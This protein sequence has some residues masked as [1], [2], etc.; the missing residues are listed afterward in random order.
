MC[1]AAIAYGMYWAIMKSV[2]L[3]YRGFTY[4]FPLTTASLVSFNLLT[5]IYKTCDRAKPIMDP[6]LEFV[7]E[8]LSMV[9]PT[10]QVDLA[11]QIGGVLVCVDLWCSGLFGGAD[12]N[13]H[14]APR[15]REDGAAAPREDGAAAPRAA[16]A[17]VPSAGATPETDDP[18]ATPATPAAPDAPVL[19]RQTWCTAGAAHEH[20]LGGGGRR[21]RGH[22][23]RSRGARRRDPTGAAWTA[24]APRRW[25]D[26]PRPCEDAC[27][28]SSPP[29]KRKTK[30]KK[31]T[32]TCEL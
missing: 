22:P 1:G 31:A 2:E 14:V 17:P 11:I 16:P 20:E 15:A 8:R 10:M 26:V 6:V 9:V 4:V 32:P 5:G 21:G 27:G 18:A 23:R 7:P 19:P 25:A 12:S 30:P 29:R 13:V 24:A 28:A 3:A